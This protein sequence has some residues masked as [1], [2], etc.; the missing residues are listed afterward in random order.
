MLSV[1]RQIFIKQL[2]T[3]AHCNEECKNG[4]KCVSPNKCEC[5]AD[6]NGKYCESR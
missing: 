2:I 6:W 5:A 4:G 3:T 1:S